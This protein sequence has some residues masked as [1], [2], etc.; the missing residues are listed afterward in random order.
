V[1][2]RGSDAYSGGLRLGL[3]QGP[4]QASVVTAGAGHI[5]KADGR[6][7]I[8]PN[9]GACGTWHRGLKRFSIGWGACFWEH[10]DFAVG[11]PGR[12]EGIQLTAAI[13]LRRTFGKNE[14]LYAELFHVSTGGSTHWNAGRNALLIGARF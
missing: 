4:W 5:D 3:E 7:V 6:H 1:Q 2:L 12:D 11:D 8:E 10:P 14:H 13:V 9:I